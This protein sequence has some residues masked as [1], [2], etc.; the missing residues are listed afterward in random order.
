MHS[1]VSQ[2]II[3]PESWI[4]IVSFKESNEGLGKKLV[5]SVEIKFSTQFFKFW[6]LTSLPKSHFPFKKSLIT[7]HKSQRINFQFN[8]SA[9]SVDRFKQRQTTKKK[10]SQKLFHP[11]TMQDRYQRPHLICKIM[12]IWIYFVRILFLLSR[13]DVFCFLEFS[14]RNLVWVDNFF[15]CLYL[16]I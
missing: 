2:R 6:S 4:C 3:W 12:L 11:R 15:L 10:F 14:N 1:E 13:S 5:F 8:L 16:V 7:P 9:I